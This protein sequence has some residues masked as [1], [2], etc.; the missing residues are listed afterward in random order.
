MRPFWPNDENVESPDLQLTDHDFEP[1]DI[2]PSG[3]GLS[4]LGSPSQRE[5][6]TADITIPTTDPQFGTPLDMSPGYVDHPENQ[7]TVRESEEY[8]FAAAQESLSSTSQSSPTSVSND[9]ED[10]PEESKAE[11]E[12]CW[13]LDHRSLGDFMEPLFDSPGEHIAFLYCKL[14]AG[15][16][17]R[18]QR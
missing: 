18:G 8:N 7:I 2:A 11:T 17:F 16:W 12:S 4:P 5:L 9:A 10:D 1:N 6:D 14:R 13:Q 3:W 15:A